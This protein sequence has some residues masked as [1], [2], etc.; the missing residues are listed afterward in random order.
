MIMPFRQYFATNL[1]PSP[2]GN[3]RSQW[4]ACCLIIC[5]LATAVVRGNRAMAEGGDAAGHDA[6]GSAAATAALVIT[7]IHVG[8]EGHFKVGRLAPIAVSFTGRVSEP[9]QLSVWVSDPDGNLTKQPTQPDRLSSDGPHTITSVFRAGRMDGIV[10]VDLESVGRILA[11]ETVRSS[12]AGRDHARERDPR[13]RDPLEGDTLE[14][15]ADENSG[16]GEGKSRVVRML[17]PDSLG[18]KYWVVLGAPAGYVRAAEEINQQG[19]PSGL[20]GSQPVTVIDLADASDLPTQP[21]G[22]DAVDVLAI[23]GAQTINE[24]TDAAIRAWVERG[25]HL[26]ISVNSPEEWGRMPLSSWVPIRDVGQS[27]LR[28]VDG[29]RGPF[30]RSERFLAVAVS[31]LRFDFDYGKT[32]AR[33]LDGPLWVRLPVRFGRVTLLALDLDRRPLNTWDNLPQ[34]CERMADYQRDSDNKRQQQ[35]GAQLSRSGVSDL[36]T[37]L[38]TTVDQ[39]PQINSPSSWVTMGW[40]ILYL[41]LVGP[42]DYLI[43]HRML[44]RPHLTWV[45]LPILV[46]GSAALATSSARKH[47]AEGLVSQQAALIDLDAES[48][49]LRTSLW[50][51]FV[52]PETRRYRV[53]AEFGRWWQDH[54][55]P[56]NHQTAAFETGPPQTVALESPNLESA[57]HKT[58]DGSP[59]AAT[60][61]GWTGIPETGFR[62]MYRSG[63][64]DLA[65]PQYQFAAGLASMEDVP[66]R[67]WSSSSVT[68]SHVG[69]LSDPD[70][71]VS[72]DL[73]GVGGQIYGTVTNRLNVPIEDW[74]IAY[75]NLAY[76]PRVSENGGGEA[77]LAVGQTVSIPQSR[78]VVRTARS[79]L[80]G[81]TTVRS[82]G[83]GRTQDSDGA[84]RHSYD[85]LSQ[86]FDRIFR[87]ISFYRASGGKEF[88]TL[89][90]EALERLDLSPFLDLSRAVLFGRLAASPARLL[91]DGQ[92]VEDAD[93]ATYLRV[94]LPVRGRK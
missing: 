25:G 84:A 52:S 67:I 17:P 36:S 89:E 19:S 41:L 81:V 24:T 71:A 46:L 4:F 23:N 91:V 57:D 10:R 78:L 61:L 53:E 77:S 90:N 79:F 58:A 48:G 1:Q 92:P 75:K 88:T 68:A 3:N 56:V 86:D 82:K 62:G 94:L 40:I 21:G 44:R 49:A 20:H 85:P 72:S 16:G 93:S 55:E 66:V 26:I 38:V 34:L 31:A 9:L 63:G 7:R 39:F 42:V 22:L 30:P 50:S 6:A 32:I 8:V 43:V 70:A 74:F 15:E 29:L 51:S 76:F 35:T 12:A 87:A 18:A 47:H 37:Q 59:S 83:D 33:S 65:K 69:K 73:E 60:R 27:R 45:T 5:L 14:S 54:H 13:E 80:T 11:T 28:N 2:A 64:L